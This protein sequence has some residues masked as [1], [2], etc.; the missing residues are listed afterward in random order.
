MKH[1]CVVLADSHQNMLEGIRGLL[2][3]MFESVVMVADETSLF[4]ALDKVKP[5]LAVVDLSLPVSGEVHI[6]RQLIARYPNLKLI[7]LS[8][9]DEPEVAKRVMSVG[10]SGFVLKRCAGTDLLAAVESINEGG[11]FVSPA[12]EK[13]GK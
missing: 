7:M 13:D 8:L 9:H 5:E 3:S 11:T 2:E 12:V 1:N 4:E 10:A 6:S